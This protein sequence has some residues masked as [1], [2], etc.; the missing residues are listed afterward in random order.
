MSYCI[1]FI[2]YIDIYFTFINLLIYVFINLLFVCC[3]YLFTVFY[4]NYA[5]SRKTEI[6][7][8]KIEIEKTEIKV[9]SINL[10]RK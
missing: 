6:C 3:I 9:L 7:V 2:I 1:L 5:F 8:A 10:L 4:F